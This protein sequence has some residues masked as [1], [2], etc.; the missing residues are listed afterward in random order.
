MQSRWLTVTR[1][2]P[3]AEPEVENFV[4]PP[5]EH[6][7][8]GLVQTIVDELLEDPASPAKEGCPSTGASGM[9][10]SAVLDAA[11]DSFYGGRGR[12]FWV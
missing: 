10:T 6:V 7:H 8:Q 12:K 9:R 3:A 2:R 5:P 11:L 1:Y 4:C